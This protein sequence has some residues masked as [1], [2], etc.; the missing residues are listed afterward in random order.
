MI[1]THCAS[2]GQKLPRPITERVPFTVDV[3]TRIRNGAMAHELGWDG[4]FYLSVCRKHGLAPN[5]IPPKTQAPPEIA[6]TIPVVP[7]APIE[8]SEP[9]PPVTG[10]VFYNAS[11]REII[12]GEHR[13]KLSPGVADV[14]VLI[15]K[16]TAEHPANGRR[17]A[18][19]PGLDM[20][21]GVGGQVMTLRARLLPLNIRIVSQGGRV[22][23]GYWIGDVATG[24]DIIV[25]VTRR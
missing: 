9:P 25:K 21:G 8:T 14:F 3:L 15:I 11:T 17:I 23:A 6:V 10:D 24:D 12:R 22:N 19:R 16:G 1:V 18:E 5:V 2:C 20:R 4:T 7:A 13:V